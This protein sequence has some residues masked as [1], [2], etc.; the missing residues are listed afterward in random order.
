M[1]VAELKDL[2]DQ[3]DDETEVRFISQPSWPFEYS[4]KGVVQRA[5]FE[6]VKNEDDSAKENCIFLVEGSQ[7]C[8]GNKRA[9]DCC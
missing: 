3:Y 9:W 8:Y 4:I 5:D 1:T 7:L 6:V 2:L